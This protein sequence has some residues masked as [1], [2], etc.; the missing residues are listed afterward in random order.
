MTQQIFILLKQL[1]VNVKGK[2]RV[3]KRSVRAV[4]ICLE[5]PWG[6]VW[7]YDAI[8]VRLGPEAVAPPEPFS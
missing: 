2:T 4:D 1:F 8:T 5:A 7:L 3:Q 6:F